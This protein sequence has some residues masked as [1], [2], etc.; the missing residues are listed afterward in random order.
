MMTVYITCIVPFLGLLLHC[1]SIDPDVRSLEQE[2][3][4][5]NQWPVEVMVMC[6]AGDVAEH[7]LMT[8]LPFHPGSDLLTRL[9]CHFAVM[10]I[11]WAVMLFY[12]DI[13]GQYHLYITLLPVDG[14]HSVVLFIPFLFCSH[15]EVFICSSSV[16]VPHITMPVVVFKLLSIVWL[17]PFLFYLLMGT[18]CCLQ[19][20]HL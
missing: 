6:C 14:V 9:F 12:V 11:P 8:I 4:W 5:W 18:V 10:P 15:V 1:C 20:L 3:L 7:S 2:H 13:P 17:L 19:V 16:F